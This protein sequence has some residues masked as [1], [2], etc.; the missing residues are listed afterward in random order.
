MGDVTASWAGRCKLATSLT[1]KSK[2]VLIW[3]SQSTTINL[4]FT[5][6]PSLHHVAASLPDS[7]THTD[8]QP[9]Q[10]WCVESYSLSPPATQQGRGW[11]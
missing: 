5:F 4:R 1:T 8:H 11:V 10:Q 7:R 6:E 2:R 3:S 9:P